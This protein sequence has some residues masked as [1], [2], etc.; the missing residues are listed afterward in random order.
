MDIENILI[1]LRLQSIK[2]SLSSHNISLKTF[3]SMW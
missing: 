1:K 3:L 2:N